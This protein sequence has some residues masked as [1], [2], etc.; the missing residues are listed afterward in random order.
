MITGEQNMLATTREL[1]NKYNLTYSQTRYLIDQGVIN[2]AP[3]KEGQAWEVSDLDLWM[4]EAAAVLRKNKVSVNGIKRFVG[5]MKSKTANFDN[6]RT[7]KESF[8]WVLFDSGFREV[9]V[10]RWIAEPAAPGGG[11]WIVETRGKVS[12]MLPLT[13]EYFEF[14]KKELEAPGKL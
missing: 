10:A 5:S 9:I 4:L 14:R 8:R 6:Q 7:K 3:A 13:S 2:P 12:E 1:A 11:E